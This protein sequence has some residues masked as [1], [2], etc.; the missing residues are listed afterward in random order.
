MIF[1]HYSNTPVGPLE[2]KR[3]LP[4]RFSSKPDG[5]WVSVDGDDD[6][7][8]WCQA[9]DYDGCGPYHY[10]V[11]LN[12]DRVLVL[13]TLQAVQDFS[14]KGSQRSG[15]HSRYLASIDWRPVADEYAGIIIAPYQ[16]DARLDLIWYYGWDCASGCIWDPAAVIDLEQVPSTTNTDNHARSTP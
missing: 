14:H 1:S 10:R 8:Q 5:L 12:L 7:P 3:Q 16:W 9:N 13:D 6:W 11:R 15:M 4:T 2:L